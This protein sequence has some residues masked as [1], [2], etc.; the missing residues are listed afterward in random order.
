M[1]IVGLTGG[2][3]SGKTT[4]ANIFNALGIPI[5]NSDVRAKHIMN[6]DEELILSI[7][8]LLGNEAYKNKILNKEFVAQKIF[9]SKKILQQLNQLVHPKVAQDFETW[10]KQHQNAP[11]VIKESAILIESKAYKNVDK[12]IVINAPLEL[13]VQRVMQRDNTSKEAVQARIANQM[14]EAERNKYADF[15]IQNDGKHAL[16]AQV[17]N[18]FLALK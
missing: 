12:I 4:V 7:K 18:I 1:K 15:I 8:K 3:G 5:Y 17:K 10:V 13:R 11:F 2:I 6:N 9:K 14:S 16:T